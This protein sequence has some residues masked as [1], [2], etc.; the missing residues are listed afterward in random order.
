MGRILGGVLLVVLIAAGAWIYF[1]L[2]AAGVF[3]TIA[4]KP[5]G[6]CRTVTGVVGVE[7]L[8]IDPDNGIAYLSG[9]DRRERT[10]DRTPRGAIWTYASGGE[11][12]D[13]TAA[14]LPDGFAPHGISLWRGPDGRH[15]LFA[16][17][18]ANHKHSV[19]IFDVVGDT[20]T[21]RRTVTGP[22]LLSP[23][24]IVG[25]GPD[26]FYVTNDHGHAA[27]AMRTAE[28]Y[29]RLKAS[30][31]YRFDGAQFV[32]ALSGIGGANGVNVSADGA[33]L[34]LSAASEQLV[35]VYDRNPET[36][37]LTP[38]TV[39]KVPGY[40]DNIELLPNGDLLLGVHSKIFALLAH[41]ADPTKLSPSHV[42]RLKA[43]GKGGF[44]PETIYYNDG[45]EISALSVAAAR[46]GRI[47][48]GAIIEPKVLDC[49]W[50]P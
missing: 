7:D 24:D 30:K 13:A 25:I 38:R 32:E 11:P 16:I 46:D 48:L 36:N 31:V 27:G 47:L 29:L 10:P 39:V 26:Q 28:D 15:V 37:A 14:A 22:E 4:P 44:T 50:S 23:N 2:Q 43:D 3:T 42:V 21:H 49:A 12:V 8:T 34:Y 40:A 17:S 33:S 1:F 45:K 19:E 5:L 41:F 6:A 35:R 20:L 9:Y 18:H